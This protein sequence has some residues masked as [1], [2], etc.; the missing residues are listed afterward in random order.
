MG[1]IKSSSAPP[2]LQA[3]S[4]RDVE[5]QAALLMARAKAKAEE[6]LNAAIAEG[7]KH[8]AEQAKLGMEEGRKVGYAQG[9]EEGR[10]AGHAEALKKASANLDPLIAGLQGS[11]ERLEISRKKLEQETVIDVIELAVAIARRVTRTLGEVDPEVC[12]AN[13]A[14]ALKL[15]VNAQAVKVALHPSLVAAI[16]AEED[17]LKKQFP[18]LAKFEVV[19]DA[20]IAPGGCRL[21][22]GAG[23]VDADLDRQLDRV[24]A[25]LVPGRA[26][27]QAAK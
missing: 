13:V 15:A 14:E 16:R 21:V 20:E 8:K 23:A 9:V 27:A 3:F 12:K 22:A 24:V 18:K 5:A 19:A 6:M 17:A 4:M 26:Q 2:K 1:V 10:K 11:A 7:E 25:D